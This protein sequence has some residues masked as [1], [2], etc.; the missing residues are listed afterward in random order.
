MTELVW[1]PFD[2]EA[3]AERVAA[4]LAGP[5]RRRIAVPGGRTP[6][7]VLTKL[8]EH[9]SPAWDAEISLTDDRIVPADHPASNFGLLKRG[10]GETGAKL[11]PLVEGPV[12]DRFDLVWLGM[13]EDGHVASIFPGSDV[14]DD[15]PP[16]VARTTPNPLP[17]EAPFSRLT[18]TLAALTATDDLIL[19]VQGEAKRSLIEAAARGEGGLPIRRLL[20]MASCPVTIFWR[21]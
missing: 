7:P 15:A 14:A 1:R 8:A 11:A 5:G 13:G 18:L 9:W 21:P 19:V 6:A 16:G 4:A 12:L 3:V 10:L 20:A 2:D 17:P